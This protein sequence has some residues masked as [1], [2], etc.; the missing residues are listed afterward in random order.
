MDALLVASKTI[1]L[2]FPSEEHY[3]Q[4][5]KEADTFRKYLS[6]MYSQ[7]PE[8]IPQQM[9]QGFSLHSFTRPSRKQEEDA[10]CENVPGPGGRG[11]GGGMHAGR[12]E[13]NRRRLTYILSRD[14]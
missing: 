2:P 14:L 3:E 13:S 1:C 4:C 7:H 10:C 6:D 12:L 5:M 8:L 11:C 9:D